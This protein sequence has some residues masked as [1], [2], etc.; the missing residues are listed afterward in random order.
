MRASVGEVAQIS[1]HAG[2]PRHDS[3]RL[4]ASADRSL[5][6]Q[7]QLV[8]ALWWRHSVCCPTRRAYFRAHLSI[9]E[10]ARLRRTN[11]SHH[12]A[13]SVHGSWVLAGDRCTAV[14]LSPHLGPRPGLGS[15]AWT[16]SLRGPCVPCGDPVLCFSRSAVDCSSGPALRKT[17]SMGVGSVCGASGGSFS[18]SDD[19][20]CCADST[21][22]GSKLLRAGKKAGQ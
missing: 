3:G 8:R 14:S 5:Q 22:R 7:R 17:R 10:F 16:G 9:P 19:R 13:R 21:H 20:G 11:L 4:L 2:H 1:D 6:L 15:R 12:G 18:G